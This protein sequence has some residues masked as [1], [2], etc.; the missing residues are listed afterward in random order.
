VSIDAVDHRA[1]AALSF[2]DAVTGVRVR[3]PLQLSAPGARFVRNRSGA[4]AVTAA[5][6]LAAHLDAFDKPPGAPGIGTVDVFIDVTDPAR[7][8]LPRQTRLQ[9]PRDPDPARADHPLSLFHIPAV[10]LYPAPAAPIFPGWAVVRARVTDR[11]T[12]E[13]LPWVLLR[14][15]RAQVATNVEPPLG[16]GLADRRGEALVAVSGIPVTNWDAADN[17]PVLSSDVDAVLEAYFDPGAT[18]PPDPDLINI[19]R[20]TL[21]KASV[22]VRLASGRETAVRVEIALP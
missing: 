12:G 8:Y 6:G 1:L 22:N 17:G 4:Y 16:R 11:S 20:S 14:L 10:A 15:R 3:G 2:V 7:R 13:G 5:R 21:A 18:S 9:L 19:R